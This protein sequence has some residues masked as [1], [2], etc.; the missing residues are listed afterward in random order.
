MRLVEYPPRLKLLMEDLESL[1]LRL[2]EYYPPPPGLKHLMEDL[3]NLGLRPAEI[4][5]KNYAQ[6]MCVWRVAAVSPNEYHLVSL[7]I[8]SM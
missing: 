6:C 1:G 7:L 5:P 3:E 4:L 8:H 2:A